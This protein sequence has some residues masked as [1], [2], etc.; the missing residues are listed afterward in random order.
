M[1][2][3]R[4]G[5]VG[6]AA[7]AIAASAM[8]VSSALARPAVEGVE[9]AII[10][11]ARPIRAFLPSA[12][13]LRRFGGCLF[14]GGLV[15]SAAHP[16][17]GGLSGLSRSADGRIVAITDN[18][19]W[20]TA[21]LVSEA[22]APSR[23]EDAVLTP[24]LAAS[25]RPLHRTRSYDTEALCIEDGVAWVGVERTHEILRF[26]WRRGVAARAMPVRLPD[27]VRRLPANRSL[28]AIGVAPRRSPIAG[29]VVAIAERS[30]GADE[31]TFGLIHGG[32]RPGLFQYRR[33]DG[34]DV[35]DL[36]FLP[37]GDMLVLERWYRPWRGVGMRLKR[38]EAAAI[39]PGA[40]V[41]GKLVLE[42]DLAHEIDNM[43]GLA[44]HM[45]GPRTIVTMVSDDNFSA[46]QRTLLL[47]FELLGP[48]AAA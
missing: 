44:I 4:R 5:A 24:M 7:S 6:L 11:R 26:D 14:R 47:E 27:E 10:V 45:E 23:L 43:E 9:E 30:G 32:P 1:K 16:A 13:D 19:H 46:L 40:M 29:A 15:L 17:F 21:Q 35:T 31:P 48:T 2:L 42:A 25:G 41:S 37:D 22:G 34:Y 20:L 12:P 3:T 8:P 33:E 28:E 39:A 38:V 18:A 36:A